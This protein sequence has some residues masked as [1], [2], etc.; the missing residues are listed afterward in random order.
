M[1]M[2]VSQRENCEES[3]DIE[4]KS[5]YEWKVDIDSREVWEEYDEYN[6]CECDI[7]ID[8]RGY[9]PEFTS[10]SEGFKCPLQK[11]IRDT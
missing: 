10:S 11:Y 6:R 3:Y 2:H 5:N 8:S 7:S 1:H 9:F 4:K